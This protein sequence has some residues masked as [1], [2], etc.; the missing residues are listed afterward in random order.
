MQQSDYP[1]DSTL[2]GWI[3][4]IPPSSGGLRHMYSSEVLSQPQQTPDTI[5][6]NVT[7]NSDSLL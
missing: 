3:V 7:V 6:L 5:I 4:S 2:N 1:N